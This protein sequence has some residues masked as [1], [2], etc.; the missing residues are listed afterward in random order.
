MDLNGV[1][2]NDFAI[3]TLGELHSKSAFPAPVGLEIT[4]T[5][6]FSDFLFFVPFRGTERAVAPQN[7][8]CSTRLGGC[9]LK[10]MEGKDDPRKSSSRRETTTLSEGLENYSSVSLMIY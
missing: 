7:L 2:A 5:F 9:S 10:L 3:E 4:I 8:R 1:S 6:S